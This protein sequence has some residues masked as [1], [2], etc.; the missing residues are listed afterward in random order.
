MGHFDFTCIL[1]INHILVSKWSWHAEAQ[2]LLETK[3][4]TFKKH[5]TFI[6]V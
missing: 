4:A 1:L 5:F 6:G 2:N 3:Q